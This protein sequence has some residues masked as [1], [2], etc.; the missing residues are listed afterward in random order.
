MNEVRI[1]E[2]LTNGEGLQAEKITKLLCR[3]KES[4]GDASVSR[5]KTQGAL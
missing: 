3:T 4:R 1:R 2:L 5:P